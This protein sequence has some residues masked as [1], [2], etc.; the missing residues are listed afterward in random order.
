MQYGQTGRTE[1]QLTHKVKT[2][3]FCFRIAAKYL[4]ITRLT[5]TN[6]NSW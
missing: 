6:W 4:T 5:L 1:W 2:D 3:W